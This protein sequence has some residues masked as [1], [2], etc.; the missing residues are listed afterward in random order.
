MESLLETPVN[1]S[2]MDSDLVLQ[3]PMPGAEPDDIRIRI[4]GSDEIA[5][6][7]KPRGSRA[8]SAKWYVHEWRV[9]DYNR[10][11]KLPHP[12]NSQAVNATYKNGVLTVSMPRGTRTTEREI[13]LNRLSSAYGGE[14]GHR[15]HAEKAR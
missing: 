2:E 15:G 6:E 5:V 9:G 11:V 12:I 8:E 13:R 3:V 1:L 7:A 10:K 4:G 14:I